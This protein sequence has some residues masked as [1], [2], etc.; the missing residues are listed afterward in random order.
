MRASWRGLLLGIFFLAPCLPASAEEPPF[1]VKDINLLGLP[2]HSSPADFTVLNG[3]LFF[4]AEDEEHG[5]ELWRSDGTAVGTVIV[6]DIN[7]RIA[8]NEEG[9]YGPYGPF[10]CNSTRPI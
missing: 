8:C 1:L 5:R 2:R 4:S 7:P 9:V 3:A 6:K 10:P